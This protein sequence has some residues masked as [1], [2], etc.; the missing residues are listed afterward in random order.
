MG[1]RQ[2]QVG[3]AAD[4]ILCSVHG[5]E[6]RRKISVLHGRIE[7]DGRGQIR[8]RDAAKTARQEIGWKTGSQ[9]RISVFTGTQGRSFDCHSEESAVGVQA[10]QPAI[11]QSHGSWA[12]GRIGHFNHGGLPGIKI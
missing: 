4:L 5:L 1:K 11:C 2:A 9:L 10:H 12:D 3:R 6:R 8:D 7:D